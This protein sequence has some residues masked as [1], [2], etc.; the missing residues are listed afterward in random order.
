M[1]VRRRYTTMV[2][3]I[4]HEIESTKTFQLMHLFIYLYKI[5]FYGLECENERNTQLYR[6]IDYIRNFEDFPTIYVIIEDFPTMYVIN[7][8]F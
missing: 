1:A 3:I 6:K 4:M 8:L 7:R 2:I 5:L